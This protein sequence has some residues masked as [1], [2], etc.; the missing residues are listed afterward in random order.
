MALAAAGAGWHA[1]SIW[2]G[3]DWI[4]LDWI[5]D[6]GATFLL[7]AVYSAVI[8]A[9]SLAGGWVPLWVR[10]T[11]TRMQVATSF[12]AGLMLGVGV[13]HL[14]PHAWH[15]N[16]SVDA[17]ARWLLVGFLLMF[18]VQRFFHFHHHDVPEEAP[19]VACCA[20]E[21]ETDPGAGAGVAM[22]A[23]A[24][25]V[26][27]HHHDHD[28]GHDAADSGHHHDATLAERSAG[29]LSWGGALVGL[30]LHSM[31]DG[32][33]LAASVAA[34][35]HEAGASFWAG[36]G[37][38]LVILLHK[39]F[40]AMAIGTLMARGGS[41]RLRRHVVNGLFAL[42]IPIG[43]AVFHLGAVRFDEAGHL[44][45]GACLAV[46]AGTFLCIATSDLLPEL[47]FH[48]HDRGKLSAALICGLLLAAA[49]GRF[50]RHGHEHHEGAVAGQGEA[51]SGAGQDHDHEHDH[52]HDHAPAA[53]PEGGVQEPKRE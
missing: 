29:N 28:H 33:A 5:V 21:S 42:A 26:H 1:E 27:A 47:Q 8:L 24:P 50:E 19:E 10:L 44:F 52:D 48:T 53:A 14:L 38:F 15:E 36:F 49:I 31:I 34:E 3:L 30:T 6:S 35:S 51:A 41:S 16:R 9:A 17:T 11:H 43:A 4:G 32:L 18:F 13:L 39:P 45:L 22:R 46:A 37:T 23:A 2:G 25:A 7:L 20:D 12:V 40:D